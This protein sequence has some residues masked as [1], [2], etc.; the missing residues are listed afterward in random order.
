MILDPTYEDPF[1]SKYV[2]DTN[3][4]LKIVGEFPNNVTFIIYHYL[5][6]QH[7]EYKVMF[8]NNHFLGRLITYN[9]IIYKLLPNFE[10]EPV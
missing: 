10:M 6:V 5:Q 9:G 8:Y 4:E 3:Y 1:F 7:R 2:V